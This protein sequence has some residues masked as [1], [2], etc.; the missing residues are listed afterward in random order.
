MAIHSVCDAIRN[1]LY[2]AGYFPE[3]FPDEVI[4]GIAEWINVEHSGQFKNLMIWKQFDGYDTA[5]PISTEIW[6]SV[7][8]GKDV[9]TWWS[10]KSGDDKLFSKMKPIGWVSDIPEDYDFWRWWKPDFI[11]QNDWY[12][13]LTKKSF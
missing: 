2:K 11:Q 7:N 8:A 3:Q 12:Q 5:G 10:Y 1:V 9:A 13:K 6:I 4:W